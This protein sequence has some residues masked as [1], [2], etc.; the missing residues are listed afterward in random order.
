MGP[1]DILILLLLGIGLILGF[2]RGFVR[3]IAGLAGL[4]GGGIAA[5]FVYWWGHNHLALMLGVSVPSW[6]AGLIPAVF[7]FLLV[8]LF[9]GLLGRVMK[10]TLKEA[11]LGFADRM[12]GGVFG[13]AKSIAIVILLLMLALISPL[14]ST[15]IT[16]SQS[17]PILSLFS[18]VA[19]SLMDHVLKSSP[20]A[21]VGGQLNTI[22]FDSKSIDH[23]LG[24]PK[25]MFE[26]AK[27]P[28][29]FRIPKINPKRVSSEAGDQFE[30]VRDRVI[31]VI[32]NTKLTARQKADRI[33]EIL[34]A[35]T[36]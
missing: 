34:H 9:F 28:E 26:L 30:S 36:S 23:I 11:N 24:D 1:I 5:Y 33:I 18:G 29:F 22:G 25:L 2:F 15:I 16:E 13:V 21:R 19:G 32:D 14:G 35:T 27:T 4:I 31:D 10:R 7:V 12:V 17:Q 20:R 8:A 3:Q 6:I